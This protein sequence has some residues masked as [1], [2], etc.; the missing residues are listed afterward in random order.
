MNGGLDDFDGGL[1]HVGFLYN[2]MVSGFLVDYIKYYE[3]DTYLVD[4]MDMVIA[5]WGGYLVEFGDM[6]YD[7]YYHH[8]YILP[9]VV[10]NR[11]LDRE[12]SGN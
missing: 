2:V 8:F 11:C 9:S 10:H 6:Y 3:P 12:L 7:W 1:E 5:G 4:M